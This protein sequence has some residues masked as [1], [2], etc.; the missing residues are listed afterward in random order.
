MPRRRLSK[1]IPILGLGVLLASPFPAEALTTYQRPGTATEV[2]GGGG[3]PLPFAVGDSYGVTFTVDES[4]PDAHFSANVGDYPGAITSY[5][6]TL[7]AYSTSAA[8][9]GPGSRVL[10]DYNPFSE[11][12]VW[13]ALVGYADG[14]AVLD[15]APNG[16][17]LATL[18]DFTG[19]VLPDDSLAVLPGLDLFGWTVF[20][21]VWFGESGSVTAN[22]M[23]DTLQIIPEPGTSALLALGLASLALRRR[24]RL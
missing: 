14:D 8:P 15:L 17:Q 9:P 3:Q 7:G 4:V 20:S 6:L 5:S 16:F 22:G 18:A 23:I 12:N 24:P 13:S 11:V 1:T 2:F 21:L 19:S 10:I